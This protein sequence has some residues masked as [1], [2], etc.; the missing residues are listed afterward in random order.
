[1]KFNPNA[2]ATDAT[3]EPDRNFTTFN[4]IVGPEGSLVDMVPDPTTGNIGPPVLDTTSPPFA[5]TE[6]QK[7]WSATGVNVN[8]NG[9]RMV[10]AFPYRDLRPLTPANRAAYLD[11]YG[12]VLCV[13]AYTGQLME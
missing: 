13:N 1:M 5:G 3:G 11:K 9:V 2:L 6:D 12:Q 7:I 8:E 4:L 10:V